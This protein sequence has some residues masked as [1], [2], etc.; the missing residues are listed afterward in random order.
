VP[1]RVGGEGVWDP[2]AGRYCGG[3]H[4]RHDPSP[5]GARPLPHQ[6]F[7][8]QEGA[9]PLHHLLDPLQVRREG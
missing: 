2:G 7:I 8:R 5:P 1:Q 4:G 9:R 6:L 3:L